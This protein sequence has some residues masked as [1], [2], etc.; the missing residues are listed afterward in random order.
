VDVLEDEHDGH[1]RGQCLGPLARGPGDLL[2]EDP[3]AH[4]VES[5]QLEE[6][7]RLGVASV[8]TANAEVNMVVSGPSL[9]YGDVHEP[10]DALLV[11]SN[12]RVELIDILRPHVL[13]VDRESQDELSR[14][15]VPDLMG[16]VDRAFCHDVSV[17]DIERSEYGF[18]AVQSSQLVMLEVPDQDIVTVP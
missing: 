7:D 2:A 13:A 1:R 9:F 8:L 18:G 12:H 15:G 14:L 11:D 5:G 17:V 10:P 16:I 3:V 6:S 4:V